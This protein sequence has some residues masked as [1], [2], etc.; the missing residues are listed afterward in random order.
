[1]LHIIYC[2]HC[3]T[4]FPTYLLMAYVTKFNGL[5]LLNGC[6]IKPGI[7]TVVI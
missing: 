1:M 2:E 4:G 6:S 5:L 7:S 3:L